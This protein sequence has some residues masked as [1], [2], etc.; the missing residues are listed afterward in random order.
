MNKKL[1]DQLVEE[2]LRARERV[3]HVNPATPLD[4]VEIRDIE[5]QVY[6]KREDLSTIKAYKWRGAY[7]AICMLSAEQKKKPII[8]ASAGNHAQGVAL[9]CK[10]LGL[11]AKIYMP[12]STPQMKQNAVQKHGG[13]Y[14]EIILVGDSYS[15]TAAAALKEVE[16]RDAA[17]IHPFDNIYTIA[18]QATIADE[19][20][21]SGQGP[22][23]YCFIAI[24][25]GGMA[26]GMSTWLRIHY[27]DMKIIGVE[28]EGQASMKASIDAG[29]VVNLEEIDTFCDGTA[30]K[31]PGDITYAICKDML[32]EIITVSNEEICAA[33]ETTWE[34]GRFIPEPSGA[35]GLAGLIKYTQEHPKA[36]KG[37]KLVT[38]ICGANMDFSKLR[39]ISANSGVGSNK[40]H[41]LRFS[42][43]EKS[44]SL[45]G[46]LQDCFSDVNI[47]A[48]QYGKISED[49]AF[50]VIGFVASEERWAGILKDLKAKKIRF[51]DVTNEPD[52]NY[53]VINYNAHSFKNPVFLNVNFPERK[54]A[55][56]ELL[57]LTSKV[58]NL[59][60]FNY[61]YTGE[62]FG[63]ALMGFEFTE[64]QNEDVFFAAID[65]MGLRYTRI[66][67]ETLNRIIL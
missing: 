30:V 58:S 1:H 2:I 5:A 14:V 20:V 4:K 12:L 29:K 22:F 15:D 61:F 26:S 18:G 57:K 63:R 51:E 10:K 67:G 48:F 59:C 60:Y 42:L 41:Y 31:Q 36:I 6:L 56:R 50:P 55:L 9:A 38:P 43:A 21:L 52:I 45:L 3:Y 47:H 17:F 32:D 40:Q 13:D 54:G 23:D 19:L 39:L 11:K 66:E 7:N 16:K 8:A 44:G 53:R 49:I 27:P 64:K 33:I 37:K 25:G 46:I 34:V 62:M 28:G 35:M 24:G 65:K